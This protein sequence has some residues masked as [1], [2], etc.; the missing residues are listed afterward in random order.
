MVAGLPDSLYHIAERGLRDVHGSILSEGHH[1]VGCRD[2][3]GE[4][5]E[6]RS[7]IAEDFDAVVHGP[8]IPRP[9]G[10]C[11]VSGDPLQ[12]DRFAGEVGGIAPA[13]H[14]RR[15][16]DRVDEVGRLE[17]GVLRPLGDDEDRVSRPDAPHRVHPIVDDVN[18]HR[19]PVGDGAPHR[20]STEPQPPH[21]SCQLHG[22]SYR[23]TI[24][25]YFSET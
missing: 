15:D 14:R 20:R 21:G 12:P 13:R 19:G 25:S 4:D 23:S 1:P 24:F 16:L 6:G 8:I 3:E 7:D 18:L 9:P 22:T 2:E 11:T 17:G 10:L 5:H